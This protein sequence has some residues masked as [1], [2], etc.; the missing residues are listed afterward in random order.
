MLLG[1][2][3]RGVNLILK[4]LGH[5]VVPLPVP[6]SPTEV[7]Y[8][9]PFYQLSRTCQIRGLAYLYEK[10]H[11][12]KKDG[13]FVEVG[14]FDGE[15]YSNTSCLAD[16]GWHG[17]YIEPIPDFYARCVARHSKNNDTH[18]HNIGI[19]SHEGEIELHLG[20][21]MT[22]ANDEHFE[23]FKKLEWTKAEFLTSTVVKAKQCTLDAFLDNN[24]IR[25]DFDLLVIDVEGHEPAVFSGFD[26]AKWKPT[27]LIAE[28]S[29]TKI[30]LPHF[31]EQ[32]ARLNEL[33]CSHGYYVVYK[34]QINTVFV[35]HKHY[36]TTYS[37]D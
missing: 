5:Q 17:H 37:L 27:M 28:I 11:G 29:D 13:V 36:R 9:P 26:L 6:N 24:G 25:P 10:F 21:P 2:A 12:H 3:R 22:T 4:P 15:S 1:M 32:Y 30:D 16:L 18:I 14:A 23:T 7:P 20:G 35:T 8:S 19:G 31:H 33:I 34:D